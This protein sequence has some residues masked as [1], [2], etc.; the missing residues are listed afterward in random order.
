MPVYYEKLVIFGLL[1]IILAV[2]DYIVWIVICYF[3]GND[4]SQLKSKTTSTLVV[5]LFLVH[6]NIVQSVLLSFNCINI[7]G[8][9]R[10]KASISSVCYK[11]EHLN[12]ILL[13]S[14]PSVIFWCLGIPLFALILLL[15]N[16]KALKLLDEKII[17]ES[18]NKIIQ[19]AKQKYGFIFDG[20]RGETYF[21]DVILTYR[22]VGIIMATVYLSTLSNEA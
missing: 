20:Y 11:G 2:C 3:K 13:I 19:Q 10:L 7:D 15:R 5:L 16:R 1:P 8:E 17:T 21:W 6:P 4:F 18:E 22:K 12:Y 14:A 9:N